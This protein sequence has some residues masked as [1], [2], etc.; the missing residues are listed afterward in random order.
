MSR[1]QGII[2]P[3]CGNEMTSEGFPDWDETEWEC[4]NEECQRTFTVYRKV[5]VTYSTSKLD[6]ENDKHDFDESKFY[7]VNQ[8]TID[9][10][11]ADHFIN[12]TDHI[13]H[14]VWKRIC[15]KCDLIDFKRTEI[16]GSNPWADEVKI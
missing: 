2:C 12:K 1:E 8:D 15:K 14:R 9:K 10:W 11:N 16:G 7:D 13:V 6:C 3:Y 5:E 4:N